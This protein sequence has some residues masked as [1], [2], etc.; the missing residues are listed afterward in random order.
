MWGC[1]GLALFKPH[2]AGPIALWMMVT[3]R[4][5]PLPTPPPSSYRRPASVPRTCWREPAEH[6]RVGEGNGVGRVLRPR[7]LL[8]ARAF[9]AGH[10]FS[11][12]ALA[13]RTPSSGSPF[14][15]CCC[16]LLCRPSSL[17]GIVH[18]AAGGLAVPAMFCLWSLL[19]VY[20]N[21]NN[22]ILMLP[23]FAFLWFRPDDQS[24]AL[25]SLPIIIL[26][27]GVGVRRAG[28]PGRGG[29]SQCI[30]ASHGRAVRSDPWCLRPW[31]TCRTVWWRLTA[32]RSG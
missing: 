18:G 29:P 17:R 13:P 27:A 21:G 24:S 25:R 11:P 28:A 7:F 1:L 23:A 2:I 4:V 10:S 12:R 26:G 16:W 6:S 3:G 32:T 5:R 9:E 30:P 20:H 31:G 8:A 14:Q 22:F 19:A 15:S